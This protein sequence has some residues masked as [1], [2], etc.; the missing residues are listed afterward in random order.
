MRIINYCLK[1]WDRHYDKSVNLVCV[2]LTNF[3][4]DILINFEPKKKLERNKFSVVLANWTICRYVENRIA[5]IILS[6]RIKW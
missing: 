3:F 4:Y 2:A 1:T 5:T 6:G